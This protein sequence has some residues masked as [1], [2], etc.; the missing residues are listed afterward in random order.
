MANTKSAA[1]RARQSV[2]RAARNQTLKSKMKTLVKNAINEIESAKTKELALAALK[3]AEKI[4]Q[5][6]ASKGAIP[7]E[8]ASR[9][10]SRIAERVAKKF[11]NQARA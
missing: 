6:T 5:K 9:K 11:S 2:K 8:R 7:K 3:A 4:L 10:T 1:K